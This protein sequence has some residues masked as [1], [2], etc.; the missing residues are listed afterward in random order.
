MVDVLETLKSVQFVVD[1]NGQ[2]TGVLLSIAT[3]E[4]LLNWIEDQED[5]V[6][7]EQAIAELNQAGARP[8]QANWL[9]WETVRDEWDSA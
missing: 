6:V 3:W 1:A 2:K 5:A 8:E 7:L 9:A 4:A